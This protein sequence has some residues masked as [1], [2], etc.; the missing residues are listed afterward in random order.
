[1]LPIERMLLIL[2]A[3]AVGAAPH[4][5]RSAN[6]TV[7]ENSS[8]K[9]RSLEEKKKIV[10]A[11]NKEDDGVQRDI[12]DFGEYFDDIYG[13]S[14]SKK[15][16]SPRK[17][18]KFVTN[19]QVNNLGDELDDFEQLWSSLDQD[20]DRVRYNRLLEKEKANAAAQIKKKKNNSDGNLE[21]IPKDSL[22]DTNHSTSNKAVERI[23]GAA[24]V[25]P[26]TNMPVNSD[27]TKQQNKKQKKKRSKSK[28]KTADT[29]ST[30]VGGEVA[31]QKAPDG[32]SISK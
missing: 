32:T 16:R 23:V 17:N 27:E 4:D 1:M 26:N 7:V 21:K 3:P 28:K 19:N 15:S 8:P 13:E 6:T 25:K 24:D 12:D 5:K 14:R 20:S 2:P 31:K 11:T 10:L 9:D 22:S 30:N 29:T 18:R